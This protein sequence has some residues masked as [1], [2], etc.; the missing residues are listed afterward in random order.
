MKQTKALLRAGTEGYR[1][2]ESLVRSAA[3]MM[4]WNGRM[5][6]G[7]NTPYEVSLFASLSV[8]IMSETTLFGSSGSD[9]Q[10]CLVV[11]SK[12]GPCHIDAVLYSFTLAEVSRS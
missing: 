7:K 4:K 2:V 8:Y 5:S 9:E 1:V 3:C 12:V 6:L 11:N 10:G